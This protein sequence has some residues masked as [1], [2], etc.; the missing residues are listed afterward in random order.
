MPMLI[1]S[2]EGNG[3]IVFASVT[4]DGDSILSRDQKP[5]FIAC[6]KLPFA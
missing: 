5:M 2:L 1:V 4:F 3:W 6:L